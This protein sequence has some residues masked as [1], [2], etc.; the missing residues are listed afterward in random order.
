VKRL[1]T[2]EKWSHEPKLDGWRCK[3]VRRGK[4]V[5]LY[6]RLGRS[7]T[8]RFLRIAKAVGS[9]PVTL[10]G[11]LVLAD[12][13]GINFY[14]M[15]GARP[16]DDVTYWVFDILDLN[17]KDLRELPLT[18]RRRHLHKLLARTE[19]VIYP[20]PSFDNGQE[21]LVSAMDLGFE[22]VVSKLKHAPYRS[23]YRPE[24]VKIKAPVWTAQNRDRWE[25]LRG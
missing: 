17:G 21:L 23:G 18:D 2:G 9:L 12:E 6:S 19:T 4:H 13:K 20:V 25:K 14:G 3:A 7:L 11:E 24:W 8:P 1:P 16:A 22:G 15:R 5:A 10:D